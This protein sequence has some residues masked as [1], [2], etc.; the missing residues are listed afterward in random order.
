MTRNE[1]VS[2][3]RK[4]FELSKSCNEHEAALAAAKARELLSA[5]NLTMADLPADEAM[6]EL[7][8]SESCVTAGKTLKTW[9]KGLFLSVAEGFDCRHL[10]VR[11]YDQEP[12][13]TFI[14]AGADPEVAAYSFRF[15]YTGLNRLA[16]LAVPELK[17]RNRGWHGA[18]LR[19]SYLDGA[20]LRI[21]EQML[22]R[23]EPVREE[24]RVTCTDLMLVKDSLIEDYMTDRFP[25]IHMERS[26]S[27]RWVSADAYEQGYQ[28]A[29]HI[30]LTP[31]LT[32][33]SSE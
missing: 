18:S 9:V 3:I 20:V 5:H 22:A 7:G 11:R 1:A 31:G 19:Y 33:N 8:V 16:D 13:L 15:L 24:E 17:K 10:V 32:G 29:G 2:K 4:L 27:K 12:L 14:G 6:T 21:R 23:M 30:D 28:D 26:K 25:F